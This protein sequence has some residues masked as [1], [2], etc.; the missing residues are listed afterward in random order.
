MERFVARASRLTDRDW[1][2]VGGRYDWFYPNC[3]GGVWAAGTGFQR[4]RTRNAARADERRPAASGPIG[5]LCSIGR[6]RGG[7][8]PHRCRYDRGSSRGNYVADDFSCV[9]DLTE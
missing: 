1:I 7:A 6:G 8:R 2:L 5:G 9:L 4:R 3:T